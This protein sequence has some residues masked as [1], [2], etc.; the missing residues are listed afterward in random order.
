[1]KSYVSLIFEERKDIY[2]LRSEG[3][4]IQQIADFLSRSKSTIST[5]LN[6]CSGIR[7]WDKYPWYEQAWIAHKD[8][9]AQR[10]KKR[11]R[12][13][14]LK[15]DKVQDYVVEK[16]KLGWSPETISNYIENDLLLE[17]ISPEAIYQ[18]IYKH[19]PELIV[20]LVRLGKTSRR[21][22]QTKRAKLASASTNKRHHSE[23]SEGCLNRT[24]L[25]HL[26]SDLAVSSQNGTSC[27]Q[28]TADR[29][30][31][32]T[33]LSLIKSRETKTARTSLVRTIR[34]SNL[35]EVALS[36]TNDNGGEHSSYPRL[37]KIFKTND[38]KVYFTDPHSP[39]QRGTVEAIIGILRR[40]FP[41]GTNFDDV[42]EQEVKRVEWLFNNRPMAVLGNKKPVDVFNKLRMEKLEK[43][44]A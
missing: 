44:A 10:S 1:M 2:L 28:V 20:Y 25:G 35:K 18:F 14:V 30:S 36:C 23:R 39:W 34:D 5:E 43:E 16:L 11:K 12:Y 29:A 32:Y 21:G 3:K 19:A 41:K 4:T 38:F 27:L 42:T 17:S 13:V 22:Y 7:H 33:K 15:N 8:A 31:R 40:W 6:R 24:E 37:E 9:L 26:E